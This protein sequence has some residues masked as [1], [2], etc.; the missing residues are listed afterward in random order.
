MKDGSSDPMVIVT[1]VTKSGES[2]MAW[3]EQ[4][5]QMMS[6]VAGH[7]QKVGG[8]LTSVEGGVA[9]WNE[10]LLLPGIEKGATIYF[11]AVNWGKNG[12][13][14]FLGQG[15]V[16]TDDETMW[17]VA[18][19]AASRKTKASI[20]L[21]KPMHTPQDGMGK[22]LTLEG[23]DFVKTGDASVGQWTYQGD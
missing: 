9:R 10:T 16:K 20:V 17:K 5:L 14:T 15:S 12:E 19:G 22:A 18:E 21:D 11:T 3:D 1:V 23:F 6:S 2:A 7:P 4:Q 13:L 8:P